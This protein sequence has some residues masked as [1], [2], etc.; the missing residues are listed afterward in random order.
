M[1]RVDE[2]QVFCIY[3]HQDRALR[4]EL[5]KHLELLR[6]S[7]LIRAWHDGELTGGQ[8]WQQE[9][10]TQLRDAHVILLLVSIDFLNSDFVRQHEL[11]VAL[12]RHKKGEALVIAV[13]MQPV[14]WAQSGLDFLQTLPEGLRP[15]VL[16]SPQDLAYVN[17]CEGI[18]AAV[19]VWQGRKVPG[20]PTVRPTAV[21]RRVVDLALSR[22][23]PIGNTTILAV[24][25]RRADEG[26]LRAVLDA[27]PS[28]GLS[29]EQLESANSFPLEF[30]R[31]ADGFLTSLD[32]TIAIESEDF[33]CRAPHKTL[34]VS[35]KG[36]SAACVFLLEAKHDGPLVLLVKI[37]HADK[38]LLARVLRAE[39]VTEAVF[40]PVVEEVPCREVSEE[41][42]PTETFFQP[43][44]EMPPAPPDRPFYATPPRAPIQQPPFLAGRTG[45]ILAS[46]LL[47]FVILGAW[48]LR[49]NRP[50]PVDVATSRPPADS[51][52]PAQPEAPPPAAQPAIPAIPAPTPALPLSAL[53]ANYQLC[54]FG[55]GSRVLSIRGFLSLSQLPNGLQA[56]C[57]YTGTGQTYDITIHWQ[58]SGETRAE[59]TMTTSVAAGD[60]VSVASSGTQWAYNGPLAPGVIQVTVRSVRRSDGRENSWTGTAQLTR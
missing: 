16:W 33:S 24:M 2:I 30:P 27:D 48:Y 43:I 13:I 35:P 17:I 9:I 34:P 41:A 51:T 15:V 5:V 37:V 46:V 55:S 44:V 59:S 53:P 4:D 18:L 26:G 45:A 29:P 8:D 12:E 32:L 19:L 38:M 39:G 60:A 20:I 28:L 10:E 23:V 11:P 21:R 1:P 7:L 40:E 22:R 50:T 56:K 31:G 49:R 54:A 36:D 42:P 6:Q 3:S 25:V 58:L 52:A 14:Q 47:L 57:G